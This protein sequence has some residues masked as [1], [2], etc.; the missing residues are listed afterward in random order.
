[1]CRLRWRAVPTFHHEQPRGAADGDE[2]AAAEPA[3]AHDLGLLRFVSAVRGEG[4]RPAGGERGAGRAAPPLVRGA[5]TLAAV[6]AD[7]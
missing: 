7:R 4:R 1:M 3:D 2:A 6:A 5:T